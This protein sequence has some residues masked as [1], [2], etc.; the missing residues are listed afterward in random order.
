M[1]ITSSLGFFTFL[2]NLAYSVALHADGLSAHTIYLLV[3]Y[4]SCTIMQIDVYVL[5]NFDKSR[6]ITI[7]YND[8]SVFF[9]AN[10]FYV[11]GLSLEAKPKNNFLFIDL[12]CLLSLH[13]SKYRKQILELSLKKKYLD[14]LL[15]FEPQILN[16][17]YNF[18]RF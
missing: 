11:S 3:L 14:N 15:V 2:G 7:V 5:A 12:D 4:S 9:Y 10:S 1:T 17:S 18:K 16:E 8:N 13:Y 6:T